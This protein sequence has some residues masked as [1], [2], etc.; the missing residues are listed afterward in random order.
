MN[1]LLNETLDG[2]TPDDTSFDLGSFEELEEIQREV[3]AVK[4]PAAVNEAMDDILC[5]LR[6]KGVHI[7][8]R[9]YFSFTPIVQAQVWLEGRVEAQVSDL[10][11][12]TAYL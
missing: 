11:T 9:K 7:S 4:V 3:A 5:E 10:L 12:L 6:R 1:D 2:M 8:D